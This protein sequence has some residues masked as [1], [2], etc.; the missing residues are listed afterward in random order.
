[1]SN[2]FERPQENPEILE[3]DPR[4]EEAEQ[5][6]N[7][8]LQDLQEDLKKIDTDELSDLDEDIFT[9]INGKGFEVLRLLGG[10]SGLGAGIIEASRSIMG[11]AGSPAEIISNISFTIGGGLTLLA[12][13]R[14]R[15]QR[16]RQGL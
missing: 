5:A 3:G 4:I 2:S 8:N 14:A 15:R 16:K 6:L 11:N 1:M 12:L 7:Q 9:E 13:D 10:I